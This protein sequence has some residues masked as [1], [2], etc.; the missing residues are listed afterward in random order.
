MY[1]C[2]T[3][4]FLNER[5]LTSD[6]R[7]FLST[8]SP[9]FRQKAPATL[10][11]SKRL[12]CQRSG[13]IAAWALPPQL[14]QKRRKLGTPAVGQAVSNET[15]C[16]DLLTWNQSEYQAKSAV[17]VHYSL[18]RF[19]P[20]GGFE[21]G[22]PQAMT[23]AGDKYLA[24]QYVTKDSSEVEVAVCIAIRLSEAGEQTERLEVDST[25]SMQTERTD[26]SK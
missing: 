8:A 7:L 19:D 2:R 1:T 20:T 23:F 24:F 18:P 6:S 22:D 13:P 15:A 3:L 12:N 17:L 11:P 9:G 14:P 26:Q 10:T 16:I 4:L 25:A 21:L 5:V